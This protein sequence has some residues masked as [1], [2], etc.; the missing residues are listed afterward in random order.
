MLREMFASLSWEK[1][2]DSQI[3]LELGSG[4]CSSQCH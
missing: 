1:S 2:T 3:Q 4:R